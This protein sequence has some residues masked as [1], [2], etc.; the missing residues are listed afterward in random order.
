[1]GVDR[2]ANPWSDIPLAKAVMLSGTNLGECFP[3]LTDYV[4]RARDSG[5]K[6]IVI[7]P[8]MTPVAR[9]ADLFLPV[10][11]GRDSALANGILHVMIDRGWIDEAFID[12]NTEGFEDV[13]QLVKKYTPR[14]TETI[15]GVPA[16]SIIR[17]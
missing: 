3:I 10:R 7:D 1:F 5:A 14:V 8:R 11:P 12:T 17:A 13:R 16:S 4:W 15:T 9:T 2:A 6:I